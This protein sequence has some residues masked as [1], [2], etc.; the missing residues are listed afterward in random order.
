MFSVVVVV[1]VVVVGIFF[2]AAKMVDRS[3][4][5]KNCK[6]YFPGLFVVWF[7]QKLYIVKLKTSF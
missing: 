1:V 2:T 4:R 3:V 5:K 7:T 6:N